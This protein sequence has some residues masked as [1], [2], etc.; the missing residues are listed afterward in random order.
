MA[1]KHKKNYKEVIFPKMMCSFSAIPVEIL[2]EL[3]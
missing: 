1:W 2:S 3:F